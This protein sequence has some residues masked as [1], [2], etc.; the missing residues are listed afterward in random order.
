MLDAEGSW[1]IRHRDQKG[2]LTMNMTDLRGLRTLDSLG[3]VR[4]NTKGDTTT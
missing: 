1:R 3:S 2:G 4:R